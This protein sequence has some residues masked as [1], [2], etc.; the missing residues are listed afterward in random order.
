MGTHRPA[1]TPVAARLLDRVEVRVLRA[2][3]AAQGQSQ[4][5]CAAVARSTGLDI[6]TVRRAV[7]HL[8]RDGLISR[9]QGFRPSPA[10]YTH[11]HG[12]FAAEQHEGA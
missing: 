3:H 12:E 8:E 10:A 11:H 9:W 7:R 2:L 1:S 6:L 4:R 5:S